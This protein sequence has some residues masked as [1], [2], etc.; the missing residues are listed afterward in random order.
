MPLHKVKEHPHRADCTA[1]SAIDP[2]TKLSETYVP[3]PTPVPTGGASA[4]YSS[5]QTQKNMRSDGVVDIHERRS[6]TVRTQPWKSQSVLVCSDG[7][8]WIRCSPG[9]GSFDTL[10]SHEPPMRRSSTFGLP[11]DGSRGYP[12]PPQDDRTSKDRGPLS[13]SHHSL[14]GEGGSSS[15]LC[16]ETPR[17]IKSPMRTS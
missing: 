17:D 13:R 8:L 12:D 9:G 11:T 10:L 14:R 2:K 6:D 1:M 3:H 16:D 5:Y 15:Q 4:R 7:S